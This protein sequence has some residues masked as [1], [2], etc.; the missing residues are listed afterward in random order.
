MAENKNKKYARFIHKFVYI[1]VKSLPNETFMNIKMLLAAIAETLTFNTLI[2][3]ICHMGST[4]TPTPVL[5]MKK[6]DKI[7]FFK[8]EL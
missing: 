8:F 2:S 1:N 5:K 7:L 3:I 4:L 6:L